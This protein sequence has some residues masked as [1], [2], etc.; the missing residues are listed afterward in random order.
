MFVAI[1]LQ[2]S[3][4]HAVDVLVVVVR[5]NSSDVSPNLKSLFCVMAVPCF[6]YKYVIRAGSR[7]YV[8]TD[9]E[10]TTY[11]YMYM[12]KSARQLDIFSLEEKRLSGSF[13]SYIFLRHITYKIFF[14]E[15]CE[16]R[17]FASVFLGLV[18][19][20]TAGSVW[21]YIYSSFSKKN[22]FSQPIR[23]YQLWSVLQ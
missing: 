10:R 9:V 7:V 3:C 6:A 21:A 23:M 4:C 22:F 2:E 20:T 17:Y 18:T 14:Y 5:R 11:I 8:L 15:G 16:L 12:Q 13:F 1:V 19:D